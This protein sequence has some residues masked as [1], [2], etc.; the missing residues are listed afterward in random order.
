MT[1]HGQLD[2]SGAETVDP[3]IEKAARSLWWRSARRT[4]GQDGRDIAEERF[5]ALWPRMRPHYMAEA[6]TALR[7]AG[8][9]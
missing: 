5:K 7:A 6:E 4:W 3:R 2:L 9:L 1:G 8:V